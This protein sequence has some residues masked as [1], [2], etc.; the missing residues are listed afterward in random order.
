MSPSVFILNTPEAPEISD[1]ARDHDKL[2]VA[3]DF[4]ASL[5]LNC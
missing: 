5:Y 1:F 2:Q 4:K 3:S